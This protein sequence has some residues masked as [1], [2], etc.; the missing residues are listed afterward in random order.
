[1]YDVYGII[2][3]PVSH[4][5]S[6]LMHNYAFRKLN[7]K[8]VYGA[9][10]V[11][12]E[13]LENAI[14]GIRALNIKGLSVTIPHKENIMKYLDEIDE[15]GLE[16]GAI[17]TVVNKEGILK[18]YNTDWLGVL[19][20]FEKNGVS[21]KDKKVVI[22][23]AGGASKAV[24]YA[25]KK[26]GA[27]EIEVYNRTFEKA[28]KLANKFKIIAKPWE[29]LDRSSGDIIIQTT[30][31]GL[32]EWKSPVEEDILKRFKIAMDIVYSPLKTKF[33]TLAEKYAKII[34]GLQMLVYQGV[35]QFKLWTGKE[36][37]TEEIKE[38][39]YNEV[40]KLEK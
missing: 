19:H 15:I 36:P 24:V 3:D 9:F 35:E 38:L 14:K 25:V 34:D 11:K 40:K 2:G 5:L 23:G 18:G 4:S 8:A 13:D 16:I 28:R 21:L 32:K 27:K 30:S 20:A 10:R 29:E 37:P 1:M 17:N 33:L 12:P 39:I 6:P 7:I 22:L 26:G 31:V